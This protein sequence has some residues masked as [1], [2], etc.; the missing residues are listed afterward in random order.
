MEEKPDCVTHI[1]SGMASRVHPVGPWGAFNSMVGC[2]WAF[3]TGMKVRG[4]LLGGFMLP[5]LKLFFV[6]VIGVDLTVAQQK[7]SCLKQP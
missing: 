5:G 2:S 6:M 4:R 3:N 1:G 7:K